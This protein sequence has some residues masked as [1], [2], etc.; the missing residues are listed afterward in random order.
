MKKAIDWM[1]LSVFLKRVFLLTAI[2]IPNAVTSVPNRTDSFDLTTLQCQIGAATSHDDDH[3]SSELTNYD[4]EYWYAIGTDGDISMQTLFQVEQLLYTSI[5]QSILW[6]T[7]IQDSAV[8]Q[9][10]DVGNRKAQEDTTKESG[11]VRRLGVVTF[12]PGVLDQYT[13]CKCSLHTLICHVTTS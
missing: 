5:D 6:C 13:E 7:E 2:V 10:L 11:E 9:N 4:F 3:P 8:T 1:V 12:T